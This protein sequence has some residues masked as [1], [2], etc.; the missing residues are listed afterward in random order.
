MKPRHNGRRY[1]VI[2]I[3]SSGA[4]VCFGVYTSLPE[5]E[6]V[7]SMLGKINCI[8]NVQPA[9]GDDSPGLER[10]ERT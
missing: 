4:K 5:A 9:R 7:V 10:R 2:T 8:A 3:K 6:R 1:A